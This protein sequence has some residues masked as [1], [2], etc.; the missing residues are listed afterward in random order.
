M[1]YPQGVSVLWDLPCVLGKHLLSPKFVYCPCF[2]VFLTGLWHSRFSISTSL[3][4]YCRKWYQAAGS[5]RP[6][7]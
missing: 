5:S 6:T 7:V 4:A 3:F 1:S 2:G